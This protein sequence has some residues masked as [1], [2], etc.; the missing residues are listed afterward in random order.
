MNVNMERMADR[1]WNLEGLG[2]K[3]RILDLSRG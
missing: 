2:A 3:R 1:G